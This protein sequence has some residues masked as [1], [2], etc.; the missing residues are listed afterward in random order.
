MGRGDPSDQAHTSRR[1]DHAT[2]RGKPYRGVADTE[3]RSTESGRVE[4]MRDAFEA[5][6]LPRAE[7]ATV[8]ML[9]PG[10]WQD[11][12]TDDEVRSFRIVTYPT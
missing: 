10:P 12:K 2:V 3:A 11:H 5:G 6:Y 9:R 7:E 8:S 4:P 1:S